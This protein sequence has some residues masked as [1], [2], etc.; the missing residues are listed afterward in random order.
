[1]ARNI[2]KVIQLIIEQI[3]ND[4]LVEFKEKLGL[5]VKNMIY[6]PPEMINSNHYWNELSRIVNF[7][8][9]Q[10]DYNDKNKP[11]IKRIIDIF[12]DKY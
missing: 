8:I 4:E 7:Y 12:M 6:S 9:S 1:M 5:I 3:P 2:N 11:W 10:N